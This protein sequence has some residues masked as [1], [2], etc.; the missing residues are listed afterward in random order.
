MRALILGDIHGEWAY[1][2]RLY[3]ELMRER[4]IDLLIQVGDF[5]YWPR[6]TQRT[7]K[8][9]FDHRALFICGNHENFEDL[10]N[11]RKPDLGLGPSYGAWVEMMRHW[12][13]KHR[14][15]Y[16]D[17][18]LFIGGASSP[19]KHNR[20][21]GYDWFPQ[22]NI[23]VADEYRIFDTIDRVGAENIHTIISHECPSEFE[24]QPV[25]DCHETFDGNRYI[26]EEVRNRVHPE[27]WYFG[28]YHE[29][30]EGVTDEGTH[31]RCIGT[32][33]TGDFVIV[34]LP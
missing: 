9:V 3:H 8:R 20:F 34:D 4:D 15:S 14:G 19:D 7:W 26:L 33:E 13:Y 10:V 5:G 17:G 6:S 30:L 22:E 16:E 25:L 21:P 28:H 18:I 1:A 31:W 24:M 32:I 11:V 29:R 12:E 2:E 27:R 23:S